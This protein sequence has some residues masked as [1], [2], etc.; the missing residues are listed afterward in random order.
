MESTRKIVGRVLRIS[1]RFHVAS[2]DRDELYLSAG[3]HGDLIDGTLGT[4]DVTI[5]I[6]GACQWTGAAEDD[7]S[8]AE[9]H[10]NGDKV[11]RV[12]AEVVQS[13]TGLNRGVLETTLEDRWNPE[14]AIVLEGSV[15]SQRWV[16]DMSRRSSYLEID[17][18]KTFL[19][20]HKGM[21]VTRSEL[22]ELDDLER[23]LIRQWRP[24]DFVGIS[25]R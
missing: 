12:T 10:G 20:C 14:P 11:R 16:V 24:V 9:L 22:E 15:K 17:R 13:G 5:D 23:A 1:D 19:D 25:A 2:P 7:V 8:D 18:I 6:N 3:E 4:G 21:E